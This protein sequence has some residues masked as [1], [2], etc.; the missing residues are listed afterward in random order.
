MNKLFEKIKDDLK[1]VEKPG[2]Y[3]G[4]EFKEIKYDTQ[5]ILRMA[6]SFPDLYEIGMSNQA[7]KILYNILNSVENVQ[8]ERVFAVYSDFEKLLK[9]K[10][11]PLY[12][13]ESFTPLNELDIL[14]FSLGYELCFTNLLSILELGKIPL[15]NEDRGDNHPIIIAGG[16]ASTNPFPLAKSVDFFFVGE[17]EEEWNRIASNLVKLKKSGANRAELVGFLKEQECLWYLNK[18]TKTKAYK[19]LDFGKVKSYSGSTPIPSIDVV[20]EHGVV[21]IMRGCP[22][23]CRFC[24]AGVYYRPMRQKSASIIIEEVQELVN[25]GY[26]SITLSSLSSGDYRY[27][28]DLIKYLTK[29]FKKDYVS[30]QL[31]SLKI[32]TLNI[33]ILEQLSTVRKSSLTFAVEAAGDD[34]QSALN[35]N[36][37]KEKI[38]NL[39]AEAKSKGWRHA[40]FYFMLGLPAS[41]NENEEDYI[42][43]YIDDIQ[44]KSKMNL[45]VNLGV[46]IP[47]PHTPYQMSVQL[48]AENAFNKLMKIKDYFRKKGSVKISY[49]NPHQSIVE[50]YMTRCGIE[51]SDLLFNAYKNGCRFD[52]WQEYFSKEKWIDALN[53]TK[54]LDRSINVSNQTG[55]SFIDKENYYENEMEKSEKAQLTEIC[56]EICTDWCGVCNKSNKIR[57]NNEKPI[58]NDESEENK[59]QNNKYHVVLFKFKKEEKGVYL[60]HLDLVKNIEKSFQRSRIQLRFTEGYNPKPRIEYPAPL[61]LGMIGENEIFAAYILSDDAKDTNLITKINLN[62]P[63]GIKICQV[64]DLGETERKITLSKLYNYAEYKLFSNEIELNELEMCL[65]NEFQQTD[66]DHISINRKENYLSIISFN[67]KKK[68][69]YG[70][71]KKIFKPT[72]FFHNMNITRVDVATAVNMKRK[73]FFDTDLYT[74]I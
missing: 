4:G 57:V 30:F 47:K 64:I 11:I 2:R 21:E 33:E 49:H 52:A 13:L 74:L 66:V 62:L 22:N 3:V 1:I 24:H 38:L 26:R 71:L 61:P 68:S 54:G 53:N 32:N 56:K 7:I 46:F 39:L 12:T 65:K 67:E 20:Q 44:R 60:G 19:W 23:K 50:G 27:I 40:K 14:A 48:E 70:I 35:K 10:N 28:L 45:N 6:I 43:E 73:D 55:I 5:Q 72:P 59:I 29:R 51:S 42:I 37:S 25:L 31:P 17:G 15:L 34:W 58:Y 16:P 36:V 18:T 8:C 41:I 63:D 69:F 9:E